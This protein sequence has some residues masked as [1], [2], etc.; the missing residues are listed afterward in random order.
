[1]IPEKIQAI[2]RYL[3]YSGLEKKLEIFQ[4]RHS[5]KSPPWTDKFNWFEMPAQSLHR[6]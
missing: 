5:G 4:E 2:K 1:M 3:N 6:A